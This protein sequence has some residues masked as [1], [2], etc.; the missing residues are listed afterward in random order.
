MLKAGGCLVR[1]SHTPSMRQ[2]IYLGQVLNDLVLTELCCK[3]VV[4]F[5][6]SEC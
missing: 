6:V 5:S 4:Y 1:V 3:V 2:K